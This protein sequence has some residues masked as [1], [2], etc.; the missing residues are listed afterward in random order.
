M[1]ILRNSIFLLGIVAIIAVAAILAWPQYARYQ[2]QFARRA[3]AEDIARAQEDNRQAIATWEAACQQERSEYQARQT[4]D[5]ERL[6]T[7][8][9]KTPK[10]RNIFQEL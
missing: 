5:Y 9:V 3:C 7:S 8:S 4:A 6:R 2:G 10:I 1:T